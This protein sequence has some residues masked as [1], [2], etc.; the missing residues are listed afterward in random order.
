[1]VFPFLFVCAHK[2]GT[3]IFFQ[4]LSGFSFLFCADISSV[5]VHALLQSPEHIC[6][7][8]ILTATVSTVVL[9][10]VPMATTVVAM[11]LA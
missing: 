4:N 1:M 8:V 6:L 11:V 9:V 2:S 7:L 10:V 3:G 5:S